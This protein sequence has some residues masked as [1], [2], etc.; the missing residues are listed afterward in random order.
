[1]PKGPVILERRYVPKGTVIMR[2]GECYAAFLI[3]SGTV[4]IYSASGGRDV[5]LARLGIGEIC[6]EMALLNDAPRTAM[7]KG[8]WRI[9]I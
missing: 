5:E 7:C 4:S 3:Q 1:M 6:G 8:P 9:A 2:E